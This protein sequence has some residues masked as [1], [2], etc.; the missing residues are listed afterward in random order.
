MNQQRRN[1]IDDIIYK[2]SAISVELNRIYREEEEAYDNRR[3]CYR[4]HT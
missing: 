4:R 1:R 3:I 2:I